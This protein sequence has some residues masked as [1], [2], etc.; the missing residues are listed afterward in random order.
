MGM[1][2]FAQ[3]LVKKDTLTKLKG[4]AGD[5]PL[6]TYLTVYANTH[7]AAVSS[8]DI[9]QAVDELADKVQVIDLKTW[10]AFLNLQRQF[11]QATVTI[12][13]ITSTIE[14]KLVPGFKAMLEA[15]AQPLADKLWREL[16]LKNGWSEII[17]G[18]AP[19]GANTN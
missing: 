16:C 15:Q 18:E 8:A 11:L 17:D 13:L 5:M 10:Q 6:A 1:G 12:G 9:K 14:Q 4:I 7:P 2:N 19:D 3:V